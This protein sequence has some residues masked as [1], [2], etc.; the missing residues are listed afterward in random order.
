M[1]LNVFG[2]RSFDEFKP[3]VIEDVRARR[4]TVACRRRLRPRR[5]TSSCCC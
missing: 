5:P 3:C 2:D 1:G 4:R